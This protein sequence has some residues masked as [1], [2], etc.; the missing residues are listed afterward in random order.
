MALGVGLRRAVKTAF[1]RFP[2]TLLPSAIYV[3]YVLVGVFQV[4]RKYCT[5]H[6]GRTCFKKRLWE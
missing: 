6:K 3:A 4:Q 5:P 2:A 1:V